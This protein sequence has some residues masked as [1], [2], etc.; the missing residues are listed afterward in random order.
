MSRISPSN[1]VADLSTMLGEIVKDGLPHLAASFFKTLIGGTAKQQ[2][3]AVADQ[4]LNYEFGWKP[5]AN[6]LAKIASAI[7]DADKIWAQYERD[8]GKPVRRRYGFPDEVKVESEV[9]KSSA[10]PWLS[11]SVSTLYVKPLIPKGQVIRVRKTTKSRWFSGAFIYYLP[12]RDHGRGKVAEN[13]I[14]AKKLLGLSLTPDTLWN[15]APWS[16]AVDWFS[17]VGDQVNN[18]SNWAIDGQM[19]LYG[20]IMEHTVVR[21]TYTFVGPTSLNSGHRPYDMVFVSETKRRL[22][23]SPYGFSVDWSGLTPRQIAIAASL[24]ITHQK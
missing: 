3:K 22:A 20:Y 18:W 17:N 13:V 21:D 24:G 15:L 2:R 16:W 12:V 11:P 9:T 5:L 14:Q 8:A 23:A 19:L 1:P 6:D 10:V 4:Y 7:V